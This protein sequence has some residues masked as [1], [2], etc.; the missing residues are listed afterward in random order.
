MLN[1]SGRI[2]IWT[3]LFI[4]LIVLICMGKA[5][6]WHIIFFPFY[7]LGGI[8]GFILAGILVFVILAGAFFLL[9]HFFG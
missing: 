3:I 9:I 8:L 6:I 2:S 1:R 5:S 4:V 7:I